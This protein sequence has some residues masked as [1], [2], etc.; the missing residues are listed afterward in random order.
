MHSLSRWL[1]AAAAGLT[2]SIVLTESLL[3]L[4]V[5]MGAGEHLLWAITR[6]TAAASTAPAWL[7]VIWLGAA[8]A[9]GALATAMAGHGSAGIP[10]AA[11]PAASLALVA[12]YFRQPALVGTMLVLGPVLGC[13]LG[14][15][16]GRTL[17]RLD[18][19]ETSTVP[20]PGAGI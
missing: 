13:M 1:G 14:M 8:T 4:L 10:V 15:L 19:S 9:G 17:L 12:W 2:L 11:L 16:L 20:T 6:P 3:A 5:M 7:A 18:H